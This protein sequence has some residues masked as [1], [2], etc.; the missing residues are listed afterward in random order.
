MMGLRLTSGVLGLLHRLHPAPRAIV[1]LI[2]CV[3][4]WSWFRRSSHVGNPLGRE[5][6][7]LIGWGCAILGVYLVIP[8]LWLGGQWGMGRRTGVPTR[9]IVPRSVV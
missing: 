6:D 8:G 4:A 2:F 7:H 5:I 9:L 1:G 3:V